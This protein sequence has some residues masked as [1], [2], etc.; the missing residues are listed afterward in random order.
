MDKKEAFEESKKG[1]LRNDLIF[2]FA[3]II[4][5]SALGAAFFFFREEGD[6]VCVEIDGKKFGEYSLNE[7]RTVEIYTGNNKEEL[8]LLV[9]SDG[10]AYVKTATCPDGICSKHKP[11][12]RDGE[13]IV[14]L[15]HRVVIAVRKSDGNSPD[16][17]I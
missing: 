12:F 5:L 4:L 15:P 16:I 7:D 2:I 6:T 14:C 9:I 8:N 17:V 13:S 11:I 1:K 10:R 3:L